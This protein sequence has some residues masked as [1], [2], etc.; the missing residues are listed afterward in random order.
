[1]SASAGCYLR[2]PALIGR[3]SECQALGALVDTV[4]HGRSGVLVLRGP[5][6]IGK[7]AL[8]RHLV[9]V[10][11]GFTVARAAG[12][13]SEMELP[14][15]GLHQ[16][17]SPWL[18]HLAELPEPQRIAAS[19]AFGLTAGPAPDRLLVGLATLN[20]LVAAS[21]RARCCASSTTRIGSIAT[22]HV[23]SPSS[24]AACWRERVA[25]VFAT[26]VPVDDVGRAPRAARSTG[27]LTS[28]PTRCSSTVLHAPVD[29]RRAGPHRDRE[30]G[31]PADA[32]RVA[33]AGFSA[34]G[35]AGGF[36]DPIDVPP[37]RARPRRQFAGRLPSCRPRRGAS[38]RWQPPSRLAIRSSCG[39]PRARS[40]SIRSSRRRR[41]RPVC[42]TSAYASPSGIHC[43]RTSS[44]A[45]AALGDRQAAHWALAEATDPDLDP[46]RR[47]WHRALGSPRA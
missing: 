2:T 45:A 7:T 26:R 34:S 44:Y 16:L 23:R 6:G 29:E 46:D 10:S 33:E 21:E 1:M 32:D 20:L 15:A 27:S 47:A 14:F 36:A 9:A 19:T 39:T 8:L 12:C 43:V 31:R 25:L 17:C 38:S 37:G 30:R 42:S 13:E 5:S 40:G 18:G 41:S 4:R 3:T 35:L 11:S 28:T 22:R 24:P